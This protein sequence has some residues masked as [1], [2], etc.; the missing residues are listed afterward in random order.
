VKLSALSGDPR[1]DDPEISGIAT[2]SR[3]VKPGD[4]FAAL[5]GAKADGASF[6]AEAERRGAAAILAQPG[7]L[8]RLPLIADAEPRKRLSQIAARF[9]PRQPDFIAGVTGT[10]GK[11]STAV[12]TA[13]ILESAGHVAGSIGTLGAKSKPYSKALSHTTPEP[14]T[15]HETLDAMANAGVSHLAMEI[16]SHAIAQHRADAV[17]LNAVAFTNITQDHLDFHRDFD[18][19]FEAKRRLFGELAPED[20]T[21]VVNLDGPGGTEIAATARKRGLKLITTGEHGETLRLLARSAA[22]Q[23]QTLMIGAP[24]G[25][26]AVALPLVGAFQAENALVAVGL[27]MAAGLEVDAALAALETLPPVPGRMQYAASVEGGAIY[28]DYAHTPDA[29]AK[30][31]T[32]IRPHAAGRIIIV[33][34]AGGDRDRAKR[35]LMGQAAAASAEVVIVTDDNPRSEDPAEIRKAVKAGAPRAIE[36]GDRAEA[37]AHGVA[38]IA[39]GD[40]LLVAGKGHEQ[41]QIVGSRTIP[42]DDLDVARRAAANRK[43]IE[44]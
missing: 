41:G 34:G 30:A 14:V 40:I 13:A 20:A 3:A 44:R 26:R 37:I 22:P 15:L 8:T 27:A 35:P 33:L 31:L 1:A 36:I 12:F 4:L 24:G 23:G 25:V 18:D 10:N 2:D 9:Y 43:E 7:V 19:Y 32:A 5:A 39:D 21:A 38:M 17:R 11:T 6:V 42:F 28:I 16:S 29:V